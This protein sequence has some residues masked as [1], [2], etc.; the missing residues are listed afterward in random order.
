MIF[1]KNFFLFNLFNLFDKFLIFLLP[2][3]P[4]LLNENKILYNEI[5]FIY[6]ISLLIYIFADGGIKNYSLSFYRNANNRENFLDNNFK[7]IQTIS[8]YYLLGLFPLI[9]IFTFFY[10]NY[11][12]CLYFLFRILILININYHKIHFSLQ[13]T[14]L[15]MLLLTLGISSLSISYL[16]IKFYFYNQLKIFDFFIIQMIIIT[17]VI[18]N[19]FIKKNY[20]DFS[21]FFKILK[22]SFRFSYPLIL[23][24]FIFLIIMHF[25]KIYSYNYLDSDQMTKISFILRFMLVI[26]I[27]H[28]AFT[29]YFYGNFFET[30]M[31]KFDLKILLNYA[32]VLITSSSVVV[33]S[34]PYLLLFFNLNFQIDLIFILIFSYT[35]IW[36]ISAFLEQYLN[37]YYLNK[38]ILLYSIVAL[39]FYI[40]IIIYFKDIEILTR[41]CFAMLSSSLIYFILIF[42][43]IKSV[44]NEK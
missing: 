27:F 34:Y 21:S 5:E 29:N 43:K 37:K 4:L 23:N 13:K 7:Y 12:F 38:F 16:I 20:L 41:I 17:L 22:K 39:F 25:V 26:Q 30:K 31:R 15:K 36:C 10:E 8:I 32:L 3:L 2:L 6:S 35:V 33:L 18:L 14:Q 28:G 9:F 24:A 42:L 40:L 19:S 1:N 11:F 44:L